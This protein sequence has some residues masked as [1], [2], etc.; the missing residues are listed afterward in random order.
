MKITDDV[1]DGKNVLRY[2][3]GE[4]ER[5]DQAELRLLYKRLLSCLPSPKLRFSIQKHISTTGSGDF[6]PVHCNLFNR[7]DKIPSMM[8]IKNATGRKGF[9]EF[10]FHRDGRGGCMVAGRR[11]KVS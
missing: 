1:L 2:Q 11:R 5:E 10:I 9:N 4:A 8:V 7:K 3:G 6:P